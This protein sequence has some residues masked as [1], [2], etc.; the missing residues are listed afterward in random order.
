MTK[1]RVLVLCFSYFIDNSNMYGTN[2]SPR[3][4]KCLL[5]NYLKVCDI[6]KIVGQ[7]ISLEKNDTNAITRYLLINVNCTRVCINFSKPF[8]LCWV[9]ILKNE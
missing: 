7:N 3:T 1:L 2:F 6:L 5:P 9:P 4:S 8:H